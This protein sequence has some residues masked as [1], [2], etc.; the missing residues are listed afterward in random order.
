[1]ITTHNECVILGYTD[2][3]C[4]IVSPGLIYCLYSFQPETFYNI[5]FSENKYAL[6]IPLMRKYIKYV[7]NIT[8]KNYYG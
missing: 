6:E 8:V 4:H 1:M 5:G 7:Q 3:Y 2:K